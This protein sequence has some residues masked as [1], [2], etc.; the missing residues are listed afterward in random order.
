MPV[1]GRALLLDYSEMIN[2]LVDLRRSLR[3]QLTGAWGEA[4]SWKALQPGG[5][6]AAM[7]EP[8]F[9]AM[10]AVALMW[11]MDHLALLL[12]PGFLGLLRPFEIRNFKFS[13]FQTPSRLLS[14]V[15]CLY[16]TIAMPKMRRVTARRSY[17]RIDEPGFVDF[18]DAIVGAAS[19]P[20]LIFTGGYAI[21][22]R[23]FETLC[24]ELGLPRGGPHH[25]SWGSLRPGG[26]TWLLRRYDDPELVR[27][28]GRWTSARMLEIYV[29]EVGALTIMP[30]LGDDV[31][32]RIQ[33]LA[34]AVPGPLALAAS[35]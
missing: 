4:W 11:N 3:G 23:L 22:R 32:Q 10:L 8:V 12:G 17:T 19:G 21:F 6:R 28:R 20:D 26:A 24:A 27:F 33:D 13:D 7:P 25:L 15:P 31:R 5:N 18:A 34:A 1:L 16:I 9:L 29:Q 35:R 2:A 14:S 30:L